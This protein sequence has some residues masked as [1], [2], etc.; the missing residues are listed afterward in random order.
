MITAKFYETPDGW[1]TMELRGHAKWGRKGRDLVCA[2][3]SILAWTLSRV[4]RYFEQGGLLEAP[5]RVRLE[6]GLAE[7]AVLP[8]PS[9]HSAAA[10]AFWTAQVG[11]TEL[12]MDYPRNVDV[13]QV[14]RL[15]GSDEE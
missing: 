12:A 5:A 14:L 1:L 13:T 15:E 2:A 10:M 4:V 6:L 7:V 9:F 8:Q 11:M 3:A